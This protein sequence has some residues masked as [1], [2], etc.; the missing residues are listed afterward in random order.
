MEIMSRFFFSLLPILN[1]IRGFYY[2]FLVWVIFTENAKAER[3]VSV[4]NNAGTDF[5]DQLSVFDSIIG[6]IQNFLY[7][8]LAPA[9]GGWTIFRGF[10]QMSRTEHPEEREHGINKIIIGGMIAVI[11]P[12]LQ[13]VIAVVKKA[14]GVS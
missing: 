5:S 3:G 11:V 7:Y 13:A 14:G 9:I 6:T 12:I 10:K 4:I 1:R 8:G 2:G